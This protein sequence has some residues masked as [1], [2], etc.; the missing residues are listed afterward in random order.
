MTRGGGA[1]K[2]GPEDFCSTWLGRRYDPARVQL[3]K[4]YLDVVG[5]DGSGCIA[6]AARLDGFGFAATLAAT[7]QWDAD[8]THLPAQART[9][10][11]QLPRSVP[12]GM[13]WDCAA[14]AAAGTWSAKEP[15]GLERVLWNDAESEVSWQP[16][17]PRAK[18]ELQ[19]GRQMIRGLGY[20]ERLRLNVPPWRVP[21]DGL[22]WGRFVSPAHS[23][24]WIEWVHST[25]RRWLLH[26]GVEC[27]EFRI[28]DDQVTWDGGRIKFGQ[29]RAR[30]A[31]PL[32]TTI[33]ARWPRVERWL[34]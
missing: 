34:P 21:I 23:V 19:L 2:R 1:R 33:F 5:T 9:L 13:A 11:G 12:A 4:F 17:A 7:L 6:Y 30:G 18:V 25:P 14:L 3:E 29:S 16:L 24:I 27:S 31:G 10:R 20:A 8:V 15:A 26:D 28:A 22:H 32:S